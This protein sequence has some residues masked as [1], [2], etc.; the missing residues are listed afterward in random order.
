MY[1]VSL[2]AAVSTNPA[3]RTWLRRRGISHTIPERADQLRNRL[4]RGSRAGRPPK[5]DKQLH[6]R[7]NV[8][9]QCFN[10]LKQ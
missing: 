6:K 1:P 4:R 9:E 8:V 10:R 7:R 3:V 2:T 5:F